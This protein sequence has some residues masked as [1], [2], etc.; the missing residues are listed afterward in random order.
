MKIIGIVFF[1]SIGAVEQLL[2][3]RTGAFCCDKE[4]VKEFTAQTFEVARDSYFPQEQGKV[5]G[6]AYVYQGVCE[7]KGE[8]G[9]LLATTAAHFLQQQFSIDICSQGKKPLADIILSMKNILARAY[10]HLKEKY[11]QESSDNSC[12]V[13]LTYYDIRSKKITSIYTG[14]ARIINLDIQGNITFD[15]S[16]AKVQALNT[17]EAFNSPGINVRRFDTQ[18]LSLV[19][20]SALMRA[21]YPAVRLF[22]RRHYEQYINAEE[23]LKNT[24]PL[25]PVNG[26]VKMTELVPVIRF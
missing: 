3:Q 9:S 21:I 22:Y 14:D 11:P 13:A 15:T 1:L 10:C 12:S 25:Y 8:K 26:T 19:G 2:L 6:D 4:K 20:T 16:L 17:L 18:M 23:L 7:G 24:L 5:Q